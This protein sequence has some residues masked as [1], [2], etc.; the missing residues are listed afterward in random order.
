MKF[1]VWYQKNMRDL[2]YF[3]PQI[4]S[5]NLEETHVHLKD[6]EAKDEE[7]AFIKMQGENWSPNGEAYELIKSKGLRHTSMMVNDILKADGKTI[8][9]KPAGW[10]VI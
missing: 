3:D 1:Q 7:D 9:C 2:D 8:L 6:I 4:D 10:E 5:D